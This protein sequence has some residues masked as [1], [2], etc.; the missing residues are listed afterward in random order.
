MGP[1]IKE[2]ASRVCEIFSTKG[3]GGKARVTKKGTGKIAFSMRGIENHL[4]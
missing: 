1:S 2:G 3:E 4:E